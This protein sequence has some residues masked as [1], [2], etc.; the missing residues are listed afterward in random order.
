MSGIRLVH[1]LPQVNL[2]ATLATVLPAIFFCF[3]TSALAQ[4]PGAAAAAQAVQQS[5]QMAA[6]A[7]QQANDQM[8]RDAQQANQQAMQNA[9]QAAMNAPAP[10]PRPVGYGRADK[11]LFYPSSGKY[12]GPTSVTIKDSA[13]KANIFYTLDGTEPTTSS[14]RYT[15]PILVSS[16]SQLKAIA[17]S[18]IYSPSKVATA[19]YVIK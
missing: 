14:A 16:T 3:A 9:Q 8:M 7:A 15:G 17:N 1:S 18:P 13:P 4:D 11:P 6:Q 19:K 10:T 5:N 2:R 12:T